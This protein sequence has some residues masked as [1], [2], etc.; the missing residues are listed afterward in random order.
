[1]FKASSGVLRGL[2]KDIASQK[3]LGAKELKDLLQVYGVN[4]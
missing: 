2:W 3:K 1:M 4:V